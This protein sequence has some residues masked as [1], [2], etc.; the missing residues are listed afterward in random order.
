[1]GFC[2]VRVFPD[3]AALSRAAADEFARAACEAVGARHR[4]SVALAGGSTPKGVYALLA[5][6]EESGARRLPWSQTQVFFGDERT[7]PPDHLDSNF[8]MA[9]AALL[10][11]VPVPLDNV[12]RI[13][14]ELF[15]HFAA[16]VC[17]AEI[18]SSLGLRTGDW[19]R[20]DL[21]LLGLGADGH[22]ASLFPGT[23]AL[24]ETVRIVR[25][26][27]VPQL[28]TER[29]TLTLPALNAA[30]MVM[31]LV[32]GAEKAETLRRV[33]SDSAPAEALPA[34]LVRPCDG[35]LLWLVDEAA[36][37]RLEVKA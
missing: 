5:A 3:A 25:S 16:E 4:F 18:R 30:A 23:L 36:A 17:E 28:N 22:T 10:G 14:A 20:F 9:R 21:V 2:E 19:P 1:M 34:Q 27:R 24:Y 32:T 33:L 15:P 35:T 11:H 29:V 12:H 37:S 26:N 6:D 8:G 31:F 13:R 7:V